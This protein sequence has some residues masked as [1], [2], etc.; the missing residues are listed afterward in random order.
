MKAAF[1]QKA[2]VSLL[3]LQLGTMDSHVFKHDGRTDGQGAF[4]GGDC[5]GGAWEKLESGRTDVEVLA[6]GA[7]GEG[8]AD[9][10][11][12]NVDGGGALHLVHTVDVEVV[13]TVEIVLVVSRLVLPP[14]V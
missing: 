5:V 6:G 12:V 7:G 9:V 13:K 4:G 3:D 14:V 8:G 11:D 10:T 1:G 2:D